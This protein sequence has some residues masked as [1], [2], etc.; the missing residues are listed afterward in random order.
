MYR[1]FIQGASPR[2]IGVGYPEK[3]NICFDAN[4]LNIV[5]TWHG[6]F[7]DGAKH[8]NGRGQGFQPPL[9]HYLVNLKR[10]QAIAAVE[11]IGAV[12]T[13]ILSYS[14]EASKDLCMAA[15]MR[16]WKDATMQAER[17]RLVGQTRWRTL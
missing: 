5:M 3:L 10:A 17:L 9:G 4:A 14:E 6:A 7:M 11:R 8:W 15:A 16:G 2:G 12:A 13:Q 1:N